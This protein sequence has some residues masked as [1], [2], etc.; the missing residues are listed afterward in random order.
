MYICVVHVI[1]AKYLWSTSIRWKEIKLVRRWFYISTT[2]NR[3]WSFHRRSFLFFLFVLYDF[4]SL[5]S[6]SSSVYTFNPTNTSN[7]Q[8]YEMILNEAIRRQRL[9]FSFL[10]IRISNWNH[11]IKMWRRQ[12][13]RERKNSTTK[14]FFVFTQSDLSTVT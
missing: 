7:K 10:F 11:K 14:E 2:E 5:S 12:R 3:I 9:F 4:S 6:S 1:G 13:E 8:A